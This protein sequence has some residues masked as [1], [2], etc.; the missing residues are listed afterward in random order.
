MHLL[1]LYLA[2]QIMEMVEDLLV[3]VLVEQV[4]FPFQQVVQVAVAVEIYHAVQLEVQVIHLP[5]PLLKD[6][7]VVQEQVADVLALALAEQQQQEEILLLVE[8]AL[9]AEQE[10][11]VQLQVP[12]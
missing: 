2:D 4:L 3:E 10:Q 5:F 11:Q 1:N 7:V 9:L 6:Q 12:L 8:Q